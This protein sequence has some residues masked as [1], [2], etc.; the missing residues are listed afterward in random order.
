[1]NKKYDNIDL[2]FVISFT[3]LF[4]ILLMT[5]F[6]SYIFVKYEPQI[7]NLQNTYILESYVKNNNLTLPYPDRIGDFNFKVYSKD[8][9]NFRNYI[10]QHFKYTDKYDC[11]YW[12]YIWLQWWL[13]HQDEYNMT[14]TRL[15]NHVFVIFYNNNSYYI[16]DQENL[17]KISLN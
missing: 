13:F 3:G 1:M 2:I 7:N 14:I 17:I 15:N 5:L 16:A 12:S 8:I 9:Y 6:Y 10:K 11:K 4:F